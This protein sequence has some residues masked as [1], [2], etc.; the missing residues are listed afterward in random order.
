MNFRKA[1]GMFSASALLAFAA[2]GHAANTNDFSDEAVTARIAPVGKVCVQGQ[3]CAGATAAAAPVAAPAVAKAA[4]TPQQVFDGH[5]AMCHKTGAAGAPVVGNKGSWAPHI[6][7]G[8]ATLYHSAINGFNAMPP[9][10]MCT[11]CSDAELEATVRFMVNQSGGNF[12]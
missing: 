11:D 1:L 2:A 9:R 5:C 3:E 7:K 12:K 6:A 4:K 10:G 8:E